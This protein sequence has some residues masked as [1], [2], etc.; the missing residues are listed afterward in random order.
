MNQVAAFLAGSPI[1]PES[2][3]PRAAGTA[4]LGFDAA[5]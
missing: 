5:E 3:A 1:A 4:A 2:P